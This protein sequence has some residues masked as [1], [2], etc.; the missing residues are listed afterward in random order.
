MNWVNGMSDT[1]QRVCAL[2]HRDYEI[3]PD[4]IQPETS[5]EDL[6]IDSIGSIELFW[7]IEDEFDVQVGLDD[8]RLATVAE[9]VQY[10][11]DLVAQRGPCP[12]SLGQTSL[13]PP[14]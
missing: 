1:F 14:P 7:Y 4:A 9:V 2:L 10:I 11:D 8:V 13:R 5:L 3:A 6:G 12:K